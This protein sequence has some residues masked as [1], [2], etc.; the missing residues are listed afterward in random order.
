VDVA[1]LTGEEVAWLN[2][3]HQRCEEALAPMLQGADL[4]WLREA[5]RPVVQ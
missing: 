2:G 4:E 5:C 3:Y 1:L